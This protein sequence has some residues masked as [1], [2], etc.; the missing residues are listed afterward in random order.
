MNKK[1]VNEI[2]WL[3]SISCLAVVTIH[4]IQAGI[5]YYFTGENNI[6]VYFL[7]LFYAA[8]LF[9]TPAFVFI[10][11]FLLAKS[12]P[13][14]VP[15]GFIKKRIKFLMLPFIFMGIVYAFFEANNF[16]FKILT[17][18]ILKN[19]FFGDYVAWFILLILQ[20]YLLHMLISKLLKKASPKIVLPITFIINVLYLSFFQFVN[21][22]DIIPFNK[23]IWYRGYWIPFLGWIFYFTLGYYIGNNYKEYKHFLNKNKKLV[24]IM[25]AIVYCL[26]VGLKLS[27][28][29][30][31]S[32]SKRPDIPLYTLT[33]ICFIF[34]VTP[35][36]KTVPKLVMLI[37]NYSFNIYLLHMIFIYIIKPLPSMN[38]ITYTISLIFLSITCS[39]LLANVIN[40]WKFGKYLIGNTL[41]I[42]IKKK[43]KDNLHNNKGKEILRKDLNH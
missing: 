8:A 24:L 33:I 28:I 23:Y 15:D 22:I 30:P 21:P 6:M 4:S 31:E 26:L 36:I 18:E 38:M 29:L 20:F 17:S 5:G 1:L 2:F 42:N 37:S 10:S 16:S 41:S 14:T 9:G 12:Y 3:R 11:E 39:I 34:Y 7:H 13:T 32:T 27:Q 43:L 40:R 19:I 35:K 25:P